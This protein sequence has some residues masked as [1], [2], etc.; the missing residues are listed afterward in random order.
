MPTFHVLILVI[1]PVENVWRSNDNLWESLLPDHAGPGDQI[2]IVRL[3]SKRLSPAE[4]S[5][6]CLVS[7]LVTVI[8]DLMHTI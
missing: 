4:L 8:K 3:G 7:F 5:H 6:A 2:Q 1:R